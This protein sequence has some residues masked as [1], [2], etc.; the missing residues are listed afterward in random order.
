[1]ECNTAKALTYWFQATN[2]TAERRTLGLG[3]FGH[4]EDVLVY[5]V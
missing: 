3:L 1:M 4:Y 2:H 5:V